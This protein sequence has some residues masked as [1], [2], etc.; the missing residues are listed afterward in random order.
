[1]LPVWD[2]WWKDRVINR[3]PARH[4]AS[5]PNDGRPAGMRQKRD[6]RL[7]DCI[8]LAIGDVPVYANTNGGK[9]EHYVDQMEVAWAVPNGDFETAPERGSE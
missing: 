7:L 6:Q 4:D 5:E 2:R 1:M 3:H 9:D 8:V